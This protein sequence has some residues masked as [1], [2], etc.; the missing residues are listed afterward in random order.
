MR[1]TQKRSLLELADT[2]AEAHAQ[3]ETQLNKSNN[4]AVLQL[5]GQCQECAI[6]MGNAIETSEGEGFIT[7]H[8]LE[9]YCETA[10]SIADSISKNDA[11]PSA[12][13]SKLLQKS[14][15]KINNSLQN[16][17]PEQL[18][19]VFL[20]YNASMWDSLESVWRKLNADENCVTYVI[21]IPYFERNPDGSA[22]EEHYEGDKFPKDVP[23]TDYRQYDFE[24]HHPDRIYI[25][26][27]YDANNYV[28]SVHPFF[29]SKNLKN[30]TD[31]LVY[32]PYFVLGEPNPD[33]IQ[34][35]DEYAEGIAHF[36]LTPGV[37]NADRIIVQ[38]ELMRKTYI[39]VLVKNMGENSRKYWEERISGE[40]S[41]K[42]DKVKNTQKEDID[43]PDEWLKLIKKPDG[44]EKKIIFY[45]TS[46]QALL[47][48][49]MNMINK[50]K[51]ALQV[52]KENKDDVVLLWRP[53]PLIKATIS[54]MRPDLWNEYEK[55][56][57]EY[58]TEKWG[59]YDDS[60]DL[61]RAIILSDA[62]YGDQSS[63]VQLYKETKKPIM[64]QN[65]EILS[66]S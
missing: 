37:L 24:G 29:Y 52:F 51:D 23:I 40:G 5:L 2:L 13:A 11:F 18:E 32:I 9:E 48:N 33:D 60:S 58:I 43:I 19:A 55:I 42:I 36:I 21:P 6:S 27:P 15:N 1:R 39:H 44:S 10:F 63:V 34:D 30:F 59:I 50:I 4:D 47:D 8:H 12:K 28:T 35:F 57:N 66:C 61:D 7:V 14:L 20:P 16:D 64:I 62:Y 45:N 46:I 41:P 38:S 26:N 65:A 22:K 31:E 49:D 25:H 56:V 54:S 53:H 3:I 17:I